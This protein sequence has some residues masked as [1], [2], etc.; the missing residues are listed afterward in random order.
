MRTRI[1]SLIKLLIP[2]VGVIL[3]LLYSAEAAE[4]AREG[5]RLCLYSVI[6]SLFPFLVLTDLLLSQGLDRVLGRLLSPLAGRFL[7]LSQ[8]GMLPLVLGFVGGFPLGA[9]TVVNLYREGRLEKEEAEALLGYSNNC[10]PAFLFGFAGSGVLKSASA[11]LILWI[12]QVLA[13]LLTGFLLRPPGTRATGL[14]ERT[15]G[16]PSLGSALVKA[17]K[18]GGAAVLN[19]SA[20]VL[21]FSVFTGVLERAGLLAPLEGLLLRGGLTAGSAHGLVLGVWELSGGIAALAGAS[22]PLWIRAAVC[23][24][25]VGWSGISVHFQVLSLTEDTDLRLGKY[26]LG[27]LFSSA[28]TAVFSGLLAAL[29]LREEVIRVSAGFFVTSAA[30]EGALL[31]PLFL[32]FAMGGQ[33]RTGKGSKDEI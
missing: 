12:A 23:G 25:L 26:F 32:L 10:G 11:G 15:A 20:F 21:F 31:L 6:P 28:M 1:H 9:R 29:F 4:A 8:Q 2:L 22:D 14:T 16:R 33:I 5:V 30:A 7:G 19:V 24:L 3:L 27:K 18:S 17:V 13:A